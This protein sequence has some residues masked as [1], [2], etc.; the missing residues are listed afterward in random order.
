MAV[1]QKLWTNGDT[2]TL[3]T[4]V[5]GIAVTSAENLTG[6]DREMTIRV[7]TTNQGTKAFQDV[8]IKQSK[9]AVLQDGYWVHKDTGV[10]TYFGLED[11]SIVDGI[12]SSP[13][14]K[15]NCSEVKLPSGVT[16]LGEECFY[17]CPSLTSI[18]IP[19]GVTS[20]DS[21]C[22]QD[23]S[24]LT[25]VNIPESVVSLG[26]GCFYTCTALTS[27]NILG[28]VVSLGDYCFSECSSLTSIDI[29]VGVTSLGEGC[30]GGCTALTSINIPESVTGLGGGCF[31]SCSSLTSIT[32]PEGITSIGGGCFYKCTSLTLA[33]VLP[34]V[35]PSL[36]MAVFF[37]VHT[38]FNIKV[39]SPY[40][41]AYK[42]ATN[43]TAYAA[44]ISAI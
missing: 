26:E 44:K 3:T 28:S 7:Q 29:P 10:K 41:D 22:F 6:D 43:W 1:I 18:N 40:V 8:L 35:P 15:Y 31:D 9:Y 33:T 42:T 24:A 13:S 11:L 34:A 16:G 38:S 32:L 36:G 30:F 17:N 2:L 23:C 21:Y 5:G 27:V 37:N 4:G 19:E 12:M 39:R 25:S 14:W 20:L